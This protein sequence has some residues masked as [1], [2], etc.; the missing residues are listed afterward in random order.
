MPSRSIKRQQRQWAK[1]RGIDIDQHGYVIHPESNL[2]APLSPTFESALIAAGG[3]ELQEQRSRPPKIRA[4]HSSAVLAINIFQYWERRTGYELS[5]A[6]GFDAA[7]VDVR[8]EQQFSSGL[9]G[10]PPTLDVVLSL[11]DGRSI[12]IESKFT[13]WMT[14]KRPKLAHF[15]EKYLADGADLWAGRGLHECQALAREIAD[16]KE[17][18]R[19]LD[20]LQLLKH[21]LG[22]ATSGP[23]RFSLCYLYYED[24]ETSAAGARHRTRHRTEIRRFADRIDS[25]LGFRALTYQTLFKALSEIPGVG[26]SYLEYLRA[27]YFSAFRA[28]SHR[29]DCHR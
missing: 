2:L 21:A 16:D 13:E 12:A 5:R 23:S 11:A 8:I 26:D 9:R 4:L 7:L 24:D 20:A 14:R 18:F 25:A 15:R 27:R 10:T 6:L 29:Q 17:E 28:V 22:L 1:A 3:G 19:Q